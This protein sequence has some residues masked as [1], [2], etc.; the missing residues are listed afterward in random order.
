MKSTAASSAFLR[1]RAPLAAMFALALCAGTFSVPAIAARNP[2]APDAA[3]L[4]ADVQ[5][6]GG[7]IARCLRQ[8]E[9]QLS[10]LCKG[11]MDAM[12]EEGREL[13]RACR[14]DVDKQCKGV[15]R[16]GGRI[17][18]CLRMH[19]SDLSPQCRA[20]LDDAR[21]RENLR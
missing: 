3:R 7:R 8:H 20:R 4:C 18:Q 10:P 11:R 9:D 5:R 13:A 19:E 17:V 12:R 2:C 14:D 15:Q 6:G 1:R 16:V 21:A